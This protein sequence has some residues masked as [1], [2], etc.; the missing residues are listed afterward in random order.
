MIF[1][2]YLYNFVHGFRLKYDCNWSRE[3]IILE[4]AD[5]IEDS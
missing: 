2:L 3:W 4:E 1:L 5:N